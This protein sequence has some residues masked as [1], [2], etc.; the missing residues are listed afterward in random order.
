MTADRFVH[1]VVADTALREVNNN[2]AGIQTLLSVENEGIAG[3][4]ISA[5]PKLIERLSGGVVAPALARSGSQRG[6]PSTAVGFKQSMRCLVAALVTGLLALLVATCLLPREAAAHSP[7][8]TQVEEIPSLGEEKFYLKV[9]RGDGIMIH[10]PYRAV[11]TDAKGNVW[12]VT[13]LS[14][15][16]RIRCTTRRGSK[17]CFVYEGLFPVVYKP[18]PA[19]WRNAGRWELGGEPEGYPEHYKGGE[20]G[21]T[22]R[23]ATPFEIVKIEVGYMLR[24]PIL[25]LIGLVWW[26]LFWLMV[27]PVLRCMFRIGGRSWDWA[28]VTPHVAGTLVMLMLTA[29]FWMQ[30]P[31]GIAYLVVTLSIS[32]ASVQLLSRARKHLTRTV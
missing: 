8:Y 10:D 29:F 20:F 30:A 3:A 14:P 17:K 7:R 4:L 15:D 5:W 28:V 13:P 23:A 12:A 19:Q 21:F 26:A 31:Y 11:V 6:F 16:L 24:R 25:T 18:N 27:R 9:W 32:I 2:L 1:D 22:E